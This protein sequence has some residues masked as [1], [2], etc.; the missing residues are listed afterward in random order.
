MNLL[1]NILSSIGT[2]ATIFSLSVLFIQSIICIVRKNK[3]DL[4]KPIDYRIIIAGISIAILLIPFYY[5][6]N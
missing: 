2:F 3:F 4:N 1:Q 6:P 5:L